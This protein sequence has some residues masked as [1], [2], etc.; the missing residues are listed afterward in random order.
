MRESKG[1]GFGKVKDIRICG[2][3]RTLH[4]GHRGKLEECDMR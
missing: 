4:V 3:E 1:T 2:I